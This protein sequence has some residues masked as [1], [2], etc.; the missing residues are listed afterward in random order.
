MEGFVEGIF[1]V[2]GQAVQGLVEVS[3]PVEID[4]NMDEAPP[5]DYDTENESNDKGSTSHV[6]GKSEDRKEGAP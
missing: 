3:P 1:F 2:R 5:V 6:P 4:V